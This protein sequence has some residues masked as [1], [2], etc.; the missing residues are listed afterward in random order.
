VTE[1]A[2]ANIKPW[3]SDPA[4]VNAIKAQNVET[5]KLKDINI[6]RFDIGWMERS[7]KGLINSKMNNGPSTFL[8]QKKAAA[9]LHP[10]RLN[11]LG[12]SGR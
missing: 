11:R 5:A 12:L 3:L 6:N 10:V 1:Y 8:R 4:V 9:G 7:N 2:I